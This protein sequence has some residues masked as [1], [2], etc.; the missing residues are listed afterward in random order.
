MSRAN[1]CREKFAKKEQESARFNELSVVWVEEGFV[2]FFSTHGSWEGER[3]VAWLGLPFAPS[4]QVVLPTHLY[5][6]YGL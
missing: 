6:T 4:G 2:R 1:R 3:F 5:S